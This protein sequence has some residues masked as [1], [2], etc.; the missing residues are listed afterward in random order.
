MILQPLQIRRKAV[1]FLVPKLDPLVVD[2]GYPWQAKII[3]GQMP[4]GEYGIV[5]AKSFV[6]NTA[7]GTVAVLDV[8]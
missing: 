8:Y 3:G 6:V 7:S 4:I 2:L 1:Q 5:R